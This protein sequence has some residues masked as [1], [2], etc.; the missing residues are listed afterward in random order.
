MATS[1]ANSQAIDGASLERLRE[2]HS[3][4][5]AT[6]MTPARA[7]HRAVRV[8]ARGAA[9]GPAH[10]R[11]AAARA[12]STKDQQGGADRRARMYMRVIVAGERAHHRGRHPHSCRSC[13]ACL[14]Q[15]PRNADLV[16]Q[17]KTD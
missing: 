9:A 2:Q 4:E 10:T 7:H 14:P 3:V 16:Q 17:G 1:L 5:E 6:L 13:S 12:R 8:R 11:H 15:S